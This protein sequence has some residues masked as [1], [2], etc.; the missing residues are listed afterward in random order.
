MK[1]MKLDGPQG[2]QNP[3]KS[4]KAYLFTK[5]SSTTTGRGAA[6]VDSAKKNANSPGFQLKKGTTKV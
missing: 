5:Q 2:A 6:M 4:N 3:Q 1:F